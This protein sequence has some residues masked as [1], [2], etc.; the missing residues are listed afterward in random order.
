MAIE[1][2]IRELAEK[3][4]SDYFG[5]ADLA[6]AQEFIVHQGGEMVSGYSRA[7]SVGIILPHAIVDML[8]LRSQLEV[9]LSYRYHAYEVINQRLDLITSRLSSWLQHRGFRAL[10]VPASL[11]VDKKLQGGVFS[12]KLAAHL[13]GLGWIGKSCLLVTPEV[14]P[15]VRWASVLTNAPLEATGEPGKERCGSCEECVQACPPQAFTGKAFHPEDPR[16]VRFDALKCHRYQYFDRREAYK[17]IV[18]CGMCI[19]ICP[20]GRK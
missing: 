13:A 19:Y 6:P 7:I 9:A 11:T 20:F 12:N 2:E 4:G 5:I 1:I 18:V 10:P 8:P 14:G 17:D 3:L 15:R 16:E